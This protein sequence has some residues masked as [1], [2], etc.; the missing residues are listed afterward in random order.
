MSKLKKGLTMLLGMTM[1]ISAVGCGGGGGTSGG[2]TSGGGASGGGAGK[3]VVINFMNMQG[4]IGSEWIQDAAARYEELVKDKK[5][6][7]K[8]GV[9]VEIRAETSTFKYLAPTEGYDVVV[10]EQQ[11]MLDYTRQDYL[12]DVTELYNKESAYGDSKTLAE[13]ITPEVEPA[14]VGLDGKYYGFP[15][16]E[17][18][19]GLTYNKEIF[20]EGGYYFAYDENNGELKTT[21]YGDA[22]FVSAA[23]DKKSYGPNCKT[24]VINGVDYST[25][26]GL[27]STVEELIILCAV[28]KED[29]IEPFQLSGMYKNYSNAL[30][31]GLW[32]SL[33][34][35]DQIQ[36]AYSFEGEIEVIKQ[37]L[38]EQGKNDYPLSYSDD[39]VFKGIDY[40]KAPNTETIKITKDNG[41]KVHDMASKYYASA[42]L[43]IA[44]KE[45]FMGADAGMGTVSHIDAQRNFVSGGVKNVKK[46]AMLMEN[47]YWWNEALKE[48]VD[49]DYNA[50]TRKEMKDL[51]VRFMPLPT[52]VN[53]A[54]KQARKD[55]DCTNVL[56]DTG[57]C[58]LVVTKQAGRDA[59]KKQ[60]VLDFVEFLY[61]EQE[62][63]NFTKST[64]LGRGF[65]YTVN[66]ETDFAEK[67]IFMSDVWTLRSNSKIL[68][69]AADNNIFKAYG[70][71]LGLTIFGG[72]WKNSYDENSFYVPFTK[73]NTAQQLIEATR[74]K[75][76]QWEDYKN[77]EA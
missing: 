31:I 66:A 12:L 57:S 48:D 52:F 17:Y 27:P 21:K 16:Y 60:A 61:S 5:Y 29:S 30:L 11:H 55:K 69:H 1:A 77:V 32:S 33:A 74:I 6:G 36:T 56:V 18:F 65:E 22:Y 8:V 9:D 23:T 43:Q 49:V 3:P 2:G 62:L 19:S 41:F 28:L 51:D 20:D 24:G 44:V 34:G 7:D 45:G 50:L 64:G 25:D 63:Q 71:S 70:S 10:L 54:D 38:V 42:F 76:G 15:H 47:T 67:G 13:R 39:N 35:Y 73:G 4:G 14:V 26:D 40:I 59:N 68:F 46:K 53:E 58:T 72:V 37:S 75:P